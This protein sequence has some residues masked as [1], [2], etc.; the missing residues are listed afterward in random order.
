MTLDEL[1][2]ALEKDRERLGRGD[3]PVFA[4]QED[5]GT[6]IRRVVRVG[7]DCVNG[8]DVFFSIT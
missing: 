8:T 2:A 7:D 5:G 4:R 1:I 3:Q 6:H